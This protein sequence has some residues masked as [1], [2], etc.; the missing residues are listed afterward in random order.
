MAE[1]TAGAETPPVPGSGK[2]SADDTENGEKNVQEAL[3]GKIAQLD[4]KKNE[5]KGAEKELSRM[6]KKASKE[7]KEQLEAITSDSEK[8]KFLQQKYLDKVH[9]CNAADRKAENLQVSPSA[10]A[11][12]H[13]PP[14]S[15][16]LPSCVCVCVRARARY[17][18]G[19]LQRCWRPRATAP[20]RPRVQARDSSR[21]FPGTA[22]HGQVLRRE[23]RRCYRQHAAG[24]RRRMC[25]GRLLARGMPRRGIDR[26]L[27]VGSDANASRVT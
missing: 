27:V 17:C 20:P 18:L 12:G 4:A 9:Q 3:A 24:G 11:R 15:A 19:G 10:G 26:A 16:A 23:R 1:V 13:P 14:A 7:L 6:Y 25:R 5:D 2:G 22:P 21:R 8:V